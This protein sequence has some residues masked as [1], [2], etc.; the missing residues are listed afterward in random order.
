MTAVRSGSLSLVGSAGPG[1]LD[2]S[3]QKRERS[4]DGRCGGSGPRRGD[5]QPGVGRTAKRPGRPTNRPGRPG[6]RQPRRRSMRSIRS[7]IELWHKPRPPVP[8][9][10]Q[11]SP[12]KM[13]PRPCRRRALRA[14]RRL[15]HRASA[16]R[17]RLTLYVH[18]DVPVRQ[19]PIDWTAV[20]G[21]T[22]CAMGAQRRIAP[23]RLAAPAGWRS[24]RRASVC[25]RFRTNREA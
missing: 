6:R 2:Q 13:P 3:Q 4:A 14:R 17:S 11:N 25:L 20:P 21:A 1:A 10:A 9:P 24:R 15:D 7:P 18:G 23:S 16:L 12:A 8:P 5:E 19:S 22:A